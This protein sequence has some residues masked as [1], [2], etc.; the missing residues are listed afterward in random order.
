ME[1][2]QRLVVPNI[3]A[4]QKCQYLPSNALL[5]YTRLVGLLILTE[6]IDIFPSTHIGETVKAVMEGA[7]MMM[8]TPLM[9]SQLRLSEI[10]SAAWQSAAPNAVPKPR[11]ECRASG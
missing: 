1:N 8:A 4:C 7:Q 5:P 11:G 10:E 2:L 6:R 3:Q 9:V